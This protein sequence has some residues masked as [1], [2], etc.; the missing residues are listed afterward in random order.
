MPTKSTAA[1]SRE[2]EE[3]LDRKASRRAQSS[4]A[5]STHAAPSVS[6]E[7]LPA[8]SVPAG[9]ESKAVRSDASFSSEVS[10]RTLLSRCRSPN[11]I[12]RS[13][14]KP[15][16]PCRRGVLV[17]GERELVLLAAADLPLLR[18][19]LAVLAHRQ[20]GARLGDAG[21]R[22]ARG[23]RGAGCRSVESSLAERL[24]AR[25]SEHGAL[26]LRAVAER[27]VAR[28]VGAAGDRRSRSRRAR[29]GWRAAPPPTGWCR[30]RA[31]GR[32]PA[33]RDGGRCRASTRAPGSSRASA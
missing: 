22:R 23:R 21:R 3:R 5:S 8:V 7:L 30:R 15:R 26:Q 31:A 4:D 27:N 2:G 11:G 17:A 28:A 33:S 24:A 6:G 25:Q 32:R 19:L 20:A 29:C 18:H 16:L 10:P 9:L 14:K 1:V 12:T 13:S